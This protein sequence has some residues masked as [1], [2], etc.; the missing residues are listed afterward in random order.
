MNLARNM[1]V[2]PSELPDPPYPDDIRAKGMGL[3]VD[4]ERIKQS[5]SWILC[6]APLRPWMLM[7]WIESWSS[8]PAGSYEADDEVIAARIGMDLDQFA[9][10][11]K[12][13]MRGWYRAS[14]GRMY[15]GHITTLVLSM[16]EVRRRDRDRMSKHRADL[17][18]RVTPPNTVVTPPEFAAGS[19][20][21]SGSGDKTNTA[22]RKRA[23]VGSST[24]V[25]VDKLVAEG[26]D[27]Q[28]AADWLIVRA[29]KK[30]KLTGTAWSG[31]KR[32]AKKAGMPP[33]SAVE[34]AAENNWAGFKASWVERP[35][36]KIPRSWKDTGTNTT[37]GESTEAWQARMEAQRKA[38]DAAASR[39]PSAVLALASKLRGG[40]VSGGAE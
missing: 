7:L 36:T 19:G 26:I 32:E 2:V 25:S 15:H 17:M 4:Q 24:L 35:D 30:A 31:V 12:H 14:D 16:T 11:R 39:P 1:T 37:A 40:P 22:P 3:M 38:S 33:S 13:L 8:A 20:S 10:A 29:T 5:T 23:A 27:P 6:P 9:V 28:I 18:S 21:G 34:M